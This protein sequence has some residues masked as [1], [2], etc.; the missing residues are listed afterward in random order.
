M[1][2]ME[3]KCHFNIILHPLDFTNGKSSNIAQGVPFQLDHQSNVICWIL[4]Y[5]TSI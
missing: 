5:K 3:H 2:T 1:Y 4:K